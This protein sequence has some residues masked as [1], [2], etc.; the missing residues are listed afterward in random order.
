MLASSH[1]EEE[2]CQNILLKPVEEPV[3]VA[4]TP[5]ATVADE[6]EPDSVAAELVSVAAASLVA[7]KKCER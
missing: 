6:A 2:G 4:L 1:I 3:S 7:G 5:V